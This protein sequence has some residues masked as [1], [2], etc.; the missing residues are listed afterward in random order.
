MPIWKERKPPA[1]PEHPPPLEKWQIKEEEPARPTRF[2][3]G[4]PDDFDPFMP[5]SMSNHSIMEK[6][7]ELKPVV[8]TSRKAEDI[9]DS[10]KN[11]SQGVKRSNSDRHAASDTSA[12]PSSEPPAAKVPRLDLLTPDVSEECENEKEAEDV[13]AEDIVP[14]F[15]TSIEEEN[16]TKQTDSTIEKKPVIL[17]PA[18]KSNLKK[19][20]KGKSTENLPAKV[21]IYLRVRLAAMYFRK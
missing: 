3:W 11:Q 5:P 15:E 10:V 14:T 7:K 18:L 19:P 20:Q 16:A 12:S 21:C 4:D 8:P 6:P 1:T 13:Q 2:E 17:K 9:F